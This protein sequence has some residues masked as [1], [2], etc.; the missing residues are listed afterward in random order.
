MAK[1][2]VIAGLDIGNSK[3]RVAVAVMD[4]QSSIP[5]VIGVGISPSGGLRKGHV[6]DVEETVSNISAAGRCRT[7]GRGTCAPCVLGISG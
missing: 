7:H 4:E 6:I 2:R 1:H 5:N 3:I